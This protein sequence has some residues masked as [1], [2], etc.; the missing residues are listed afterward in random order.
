MAAFHLGSNRSIDGVVEMMLDASQKF[1]VPLTK[2]RLFTWHTLLF[3]ANVKR[4]SN[5]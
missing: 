1:D 5:I 2:E 4:F 3:P